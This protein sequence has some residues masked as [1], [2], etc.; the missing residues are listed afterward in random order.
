MRNIIYY[1]RP[2]ILALASC[3]ANNKTLNGQR[4]LKWFVEIQVVLIFSIRLDCSF[5]IKWH[6][7]HRDGI[8]R[9]LQDGRIIHRLLTEFH[10]YKLLI[11]HEVSSILKYYSAFTRRCKSVGGGSESKLY[12]NFH[13]VSC[14]FHFI[15]DFRAVSPMADAARAEEQNEKT[16]WFPNIHSKTEH[17]DCLYIVIMN[18]ASNNIQLIA[19]FVG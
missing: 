12:T 7:C 4:N 2:D 3:K 6:L 5:V 14:H 11:V 10:S 16:V 8:F 1:R 17:T 19:S 15:S 13:F 18:T 9:S